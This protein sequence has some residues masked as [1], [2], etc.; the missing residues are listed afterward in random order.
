VICGN[1]ANFTFGLL[2]RVDAELERGTF[3]DVDVAGEEGSRPSPT[4]E[5]SLEDMEE[6]EMTD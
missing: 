1:G 6:W 3:D 5:R 2:F 4:S